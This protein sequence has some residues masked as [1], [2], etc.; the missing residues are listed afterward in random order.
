VPS[1]RVRRCVLVASAVASAS[2]AQF[3]VVVYGGTAGGV[4]AAVSAA[5]EKASVALLEP[6]RHLGGMTS[7]GLGRTDHGKKENIGGYSLE[8]YKRVGKHYGEDVTWYFEPHAAEQV[9]REMAAEA[10]VKVFYE[11]RL[12]EQRG[13]K[14]SRRRIQS[15][16]TENAATFE[17][18]VF[19]DA[20]YEGDLMAK[21]GASYTVGRE[22]ASQYR[23]TLAGVRPKDRAHQFDFA[24]SGV[25][26]S[27]T[28]LHGIQS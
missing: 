1:D 7:G 16:V 24:V 23:E 18:K 2:A 15:I 14:T 11:H 21:A 12:R 6:G 28:P 22:G 4:I 20:T 17:A 26:A 9:L 25:D 10:G 19:M 13:V 5:R 27:G 3:D 8:F